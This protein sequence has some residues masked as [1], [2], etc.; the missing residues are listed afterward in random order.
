MASRRGFLAAL[1]GV[2]ACPGWRTWGTGAQIWRENMYIPSPNHK[3][4]LKRE[5]QPKYI[6]VSE[7][8]RRAFR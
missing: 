7:R 5:P 4:A 8:F 3:E 1:A 2:F 6:L